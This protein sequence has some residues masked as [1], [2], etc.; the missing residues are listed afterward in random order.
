[1]RPKLKIALS[2]SDKIIEIIGLMTLISLWLFVIFNYSK[3]PN[4]IPTHFVSS[5]Q[6][7]RYG[8]KINLLMLPIVPSVIFIGFSIL[9]KFPHIFNYPTD[10]SEENAL[11]YYTLATRMIRV[12]KL[13]IVVIFGIIALRTIQLATGQIDKIGIWLLPL[14]LGLVFIPILYFLV[15]MSK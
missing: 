9:N 5:S 14:V 3:L 2:K 6:P 12:M 4:T 10:I 15:R 1:M 7:D 8:G 13:I 11:K